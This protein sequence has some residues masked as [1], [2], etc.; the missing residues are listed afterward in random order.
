MPARKTGF[1][2]GAV[3]GIGVAAAAMAG[4]GLRAS[5]AAD[6]PGLTRAA[7]TS[8]MF[9]PPPGSPKS[10]ADIFEEVSPAV[11]SIEVTSKVDARTLR[12]IPGLPFGLVPPGGGGDDN[13]GAD[14]GGPTPPDG[15]RAPK[16]Q[17]QGSG[18]F[19][20][21][22][23]Y[24]V[25]NNHVVEGADDIKVIMKDG[26]ELKA[27]LVGRDENTDIAVV[28]V[29][30]SNFPFV[31]FE[32][33]AK[34]RVGDWV[35]AVGNP[36]GLGGTATA[37]IVSSYGRDIGDQFVDYIQID[38]PINRG[39]S[40]GPTFDIYGRVIGVNSAIFSPSG[41]SV[42]IGFAIPADIADSISKQLISG[43]KIQRG[44]MGATIQTLSDEIAEARGLK[45]QKGALVSSLAP[46]GPAEKA[47]LRPYDVIL[48][49]N[50]VPVASNTAL[51]REV[52]KVAVGGKIHLE[53]MRDDQKKTIDIV[54]GRRPSEQELIAAASGSG[55]PDARP[56]NPTAPPTV[57][58]VQ[59]MV[60]QPLDPA[61]RGALKLDPNTKGVIVQSVR[62]DSDAAD[63]GLQ[64]GDVITS[65]NNRPVTNS[66]EVAANVEAAKKAG[67]SNVLLGFMRGGQSG[68][69]PLKIE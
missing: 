34:P 32:N 46:G 53:I 26:R 41:G 51:T 28:K 61:I 35:I 42:G 7:N 54:S 56:V 49:I 60:L 25:T 2:V 30:G 33:S 8:V 43:G 9:A 17:S 52:A 67:R 40:G 13:G 68:Y 16:Q 6:Q 15:A 21:A 23:G 45:G 69:L 59:G 4:M 14:E 62:G 63:K 20:S 64:K 19:I 24:I 55:G 65:V 50:G 1:L 47:G 11:V 27:T 58:P 3:A 36:F 5:Q 12:Q 37:G 10:F 57:K 31:S 66:T 38:A 29:E 48:S 39:N 22:D 44:Y 18:F